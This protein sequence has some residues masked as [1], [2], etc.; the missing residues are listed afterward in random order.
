MNIQV[1][2]VAVYFVSVDTI[3]NVENRMSYWAVSK[4]LKKM[5][6]NSYKN[7]IPIR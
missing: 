4:K 3:A 7:R 1:I 5:M 2:G 6:M